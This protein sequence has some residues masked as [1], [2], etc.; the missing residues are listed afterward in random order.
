VRRDGRELLNLASVNLLAPQAMPEVRETFQEAVEAYGLVTGG[1]RMTQGVCR[2]HR[3]LEE[4]LARAT[5]KEDAITF[6][7]GLLANI[8]FTNAMTT[9]FALG[10]SCQ[11]ANQDAVFVLDHDSHWSLWKGVSHLRMGKRLFAFRHNDPESLERVLRVHQSDK[12]VVVF[13]TVYSSDGS[14][15]P[16]GALRDVCERYAALSYVDDA[17]GFLIYGPAHRPFAAEFAEVG[18]ATFHMVSFSKAVGMEGGG[19]AGPSDAITAFEW[20]SGTSM[21][22]AAMQPPTAATACK[23]AE[24]LLAVPSLVDRYL[25]RVRLFRE[26][27]LE[28]GCVLNETP[29]YITSIFIGDDEVAARARDAFFERGLCVPVFR[30][31]AVRRNRAVISPGP[32]RSASSCRPGARARLAVFRDLWP[33]GPLEELGPELAALG[34]RP[35]SMYRNARLAISWASFEE[36][37][38]ALR[39]KV[40]NAVRKDLRSL[41]ERGYERAL[42]RGEE[43]SARADELLM[44]WQQV[45][46]RHRERDQIPLGADY[47][48]EVTALPNAIVLALLRRGSLAGFTLLFA[49][50]RLLEATYCGVD[51]RSTGTDPVQR[52]SMAAMARYAIEQ[53]F[54]ELEYGISN[55]TVKSR[56]G[57]SFRSLQWFARPVPGALAKLPLERLVLSGY[58]AEEPLARA[59]H[60][61]RPGRPSPKG[62]KAP[63]AGNR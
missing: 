28:L 62:A 46:A 44:L 14:A 36:Y 21:F 9:N 12:V 6:A 19:I 58:Q 8:G 5:G 2:P 49:H 40:R 20:S 55:D 18:R 48:R 45:N 11:L 43:A 51:Y 23:V 24:H 13:E 32:G 57:S 25:D 41:E 35:V 27:L 26:K 4:L 50:G 17:N 34:C 30:D 29:S 33:G 56:M 38:D 63:Q 60:G 16:V 31:P 61:P 54:A 39:H 1:S 47:F 10:P 3:Q 42:L 22:T 59:F 53:G 15:A 7:T 52:A 37:L